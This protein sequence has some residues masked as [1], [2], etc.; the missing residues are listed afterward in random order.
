M[1]LYISGFNSTPKAFI[2][3]NQSVDVYYVIENDYAKDI[4]Q[5]G[6]IIRQ[7]P[8]YIDITG[9]STGGFYALTLKT[10]FPDQIRRLHLINPAMDLVK[11]LGNNPEPKAQEFL[12]NGRTDMIAQHSRNHALSKNPDVFLY[13]GLLDDRVDVQYNTLFVREENTCV[14]PDMGHRFSEQEFLQ[15]MRDILSQQG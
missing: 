7:H 3:N 13:Q 9:H 15:I 11:I 8:N 4:S 12:E 6:E 14:Y 5:L 1:L 2:S 10:I